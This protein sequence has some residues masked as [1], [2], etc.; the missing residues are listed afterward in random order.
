MSSDTR[1]PSHFG[2][3]ILLDRVASGG[4]AE[5]YRAKISGVAEFQRLLAIKCMLPNL[6]EDEDFIKMFIYYIR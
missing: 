1:F 2:K 3:Y 5:V 4:M 6:V